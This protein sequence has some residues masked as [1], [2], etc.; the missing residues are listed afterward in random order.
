VGL[1]IYSFNSPGSACTNRRNLLAELDAFSKTD[2]PELIAIRAV[3]LDRIAAAKQPLQ[4]FDAIT[5][6]RLLALTG[7]TRRCEHD[8]L[9]HGGAKMRPSLPG[10]YRAI[11]PAYVGALP[12]SLRAVSWD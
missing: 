10:S 1:S 8:D 2:G 12:T 9:D 4:G 5:V 7:G 6:L 3:R 11:N